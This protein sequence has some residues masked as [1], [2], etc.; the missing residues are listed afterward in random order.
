[1]DSGLL[2]MLHLLTALGVHADASQIEHERGT[3]TGA[4]SVNDIVRSAKRLGVRCRA[5]SANTDKLRRL[6]LPAIGQSHD[7]SFFLIAKII[8]QPAAAGGLV[9]TRILVLTSEENDPKVWTVDELESRWSGIIILMTTRETLSG[10]KRHFGISWFIPFLVKYRN[11]L[12]Q[13]L[14]ATFTIQIVGLVSPLF[15]QLIIDKV[16]VHGALSTLDVLAFGLAFVFVWEALLVG[17][18]QWLLSHTT[19]RIDAELGSSLYRHML[20]LPLAYFENRRVG[21]TVAR[22][23]ELDTIRQFL[24]GPALAVGLDLLFT[25]VFICVMYLYSPVLT[26]LV[27]ISFP[28]YAI[29]TALV[30][31]PLRKGLDEKFNRSADNQAFLVE[32]VSAVRT[33]KSMAVE[34]RMR[35][36]WE[37]KLA[38]YVQSS[39]A[40]ARMGIFGSGAIQLVS[41]LTTVLVLYIGAK[42]VISGDLTVGGLV[43][44]NMLAGRVAA[45]ILRLSQLVQDVQQ[46][47]VSI[48]RLGDVLNAKTEPENDPSKTV[49]PPIKGEIT[50]E[51]V[52][53]RYGP[54]LPEV[55]QGIDLSIK[56]GRVI[57][58]VGPSGSG[59]STF[60]SLIQR[61][62]VPTSGRILVDGVDLVLVD[63]AWLRK[64]VGV[65]LQENELLNRSV[66]ENI[67]L[68][69]PR[70]SID[71]LIKVAKLA[72]AHEFILQMPFGY[73]TKIEERGR[74]LSGGQRQRLAIARA[75]IGD[76][77]IL[78]LDEATSS[79]DAE[80]EEIIQKNLK[81]IS[82]GRTVIIVAHRLSAV[83][84]A[85]LIVTIDQGLISESGT[86]TE[87]MTKNGRYASLYKKQ[88]GQNDDQYL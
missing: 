58:V 4:F 36:D 81:K 56:A 41:K 18:R 70:I 5:I 34:P 35:D 31:P 17:G 68:S 9:T 30:V 75:L 69:N 63:G 60:T 72:G 15:F 46:V 19:S 47:N 1:M 6:H 44:F 76:P 16:L 33:L 14:I 40:V 3:G 82:A 67:A 80:S 37:R 32:S 79:L 43:A 22:V 65:V 64:Q 59:K 87:L 25:L 73:D 49:L 2:A 62:H 54:D 77:R 24:T 84:Q 48:Q 7:G 61:L 38:G 71:E 26:L 45:P 39:F 66:R 57:G 29:V 8:D 50:L 86:H 12:L 51:R 13:V 20:N 28:F 74:N 10:L 27:I 55:L 88:M 85:D 83:R 11:P 53:F 21:D 42:Q 23:R 78:I 52:R